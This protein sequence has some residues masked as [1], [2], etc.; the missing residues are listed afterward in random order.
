MLCEYGIFIFLAEDLFGTDDDQTYEPENET[1]SKSSEDVPGAD[2]ED[3]TEVD[4][5]FRPRK[6]SR[7]EREWSKAKAKDLRN[8]RK[9]LI[10]K[11]GIQHTE[12]SV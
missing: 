5:N 3:K 6:R 9:A 10:G 2:E 1:E 7:K 8:S 12:R 4:N 11:R